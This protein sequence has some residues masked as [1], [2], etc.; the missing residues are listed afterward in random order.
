MAQLPDS[1]ARPDYFFI[2]I[3]QIYNTPI[4]A[5]II[6]A[7]IIDVFAIRRFSGWLSKPSVA[8]R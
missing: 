4:N 8:I 7:N 3:T 6:E 2:E 5:E 1:Q